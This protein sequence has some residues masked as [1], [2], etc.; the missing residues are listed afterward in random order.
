MV[1]IQKAVDEDPKFHST[2]EEYDLELRQALAMHRKTL[3][4]GTRLT[5]KGAAK[6]VLETALFVHK[7]VS[8]PLANPSTVTNTYLSVRS[9]H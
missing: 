4:T 7:E 8:H 9:M 6:D 5:R 1:E 2:T 3:R